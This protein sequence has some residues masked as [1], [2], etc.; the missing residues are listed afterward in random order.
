M[1]LEENNLIQGVK[2][3]CS[4]IR[5]IQKERLAALKRRL[6]RKNEINEL[7]FQA[8]KSSHSLLWVWEFSKKLVLICVTFHIIT[9]IYAMLVMVIF[10]DF[11]CLGEFLT[12]NGLI[13]RECVFGYLV[14][15]GVE[16]LVKL[17]PRHKEPNEED[18]VG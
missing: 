14:K 6:K 18:A 8:Q 5:A 13:V 17:W 3:M 2:V 16:N 9:Q 1:R 7:K 11:S 15:S 12:Q 4:L 10:C